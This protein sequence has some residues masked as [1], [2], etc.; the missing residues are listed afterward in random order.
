MVCVICVTLWYNVQSCSVFGFY[1]NNCKKCKK[2]HIIQADGFFGSS[3]FVGQYTG[4]DTLGTCHNVIQKDYSERL[5]YKHAS[6]D[7]SP[8]KTFCSLPVKSVKTNE[9]LKHI[10]NLIKHAHVVKYSWKWCMLLDVT[11]NGACIHFLSESAK[12][13]D[14]GLWCFSKIIQ[15]EKQKKVTPTSV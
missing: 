2:C 4:V 15:N 5:I 12:V 9:A 11:D 7:D 8:V 10:S 6:S 1:C 14:S 13:S 3:R